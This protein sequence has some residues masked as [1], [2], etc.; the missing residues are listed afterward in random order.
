[1]RDTF[2]R[3]VT[4]FLEDRVSRITVPVLI[5]WGTND[6]AVS[7]TQIK[8]LEELLPDAGLVRLEGAGHYGFLDDPETFL[9]GTRYFLDLNT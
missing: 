1:M 3:T 8:R 6:T 4:C 5:F 2:V 9:S 7:E